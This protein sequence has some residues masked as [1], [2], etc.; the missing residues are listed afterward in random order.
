MLCPGVMLNL[1]QRALPGASTKSCA[2]A[3]VPSSLNAFGQESLSCELTR[4]GD[5][6]LA[7]G[8]VT[9]TVTKAP[10]LTPETDTP[11]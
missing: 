6:G 9:C 2:V 10:G 3:A 11:K 7:V 5:D 4:H 8:E 1:Y